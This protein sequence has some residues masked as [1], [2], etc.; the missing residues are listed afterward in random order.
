MVPRP[1]ERQDPKKTMN[2]EPIPIRWQPKMSIFARESS[3][4]AVGDEYGWLGGLSET[5]PPRKLSAAEDCP[6]RD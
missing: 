6:C 2:E 3:L 5:G 4:K 1:F